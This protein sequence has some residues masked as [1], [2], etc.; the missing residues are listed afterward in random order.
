MRS[1]VMS[2]LLVGLRAGTLTLEELSARVEHSFLRELEPDPEQQEHAPNRR[3]RE[4]ESGHYV[5]ALSLQP[6]RSPYV[7]ACSEEMLDLLGLDPGECVPY[8]VAPAA[9]NGGGAPT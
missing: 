7:V 5:D 9:G 2:V 8:L 6:L 4:V 1:S 3:S